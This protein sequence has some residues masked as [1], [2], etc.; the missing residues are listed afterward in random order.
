MFILQ[1]RRVLFIEKA[2]AV[3]GIL[4]TLTMTAGCGN[5]NQGNTTTAESQTQDAAGEENTRA[6][7]ENADNEESERADQKQT[8]GDNANTA[9]AEVTETGEESSKVLVAYYSAT[10]NTKAAAEAITEA[11]NGELFELQP[12]ET[13]T[14]EDLNYNDPE[15]RVCKEHD[16]PDLQDVKL[17]E[18]TPEDFSDVDVVFLGYPIWWGEA[19]WPVNEFVKEN[20]FTGKTVI[21]FCTSAS[22]GLGDSGKLLEEMAGTGDWQEGKRFSSNVSEEEIQDWVGSFDLAVK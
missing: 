7:S 19:A 13:Y 17:A 4:F 2:I 9:E 16:D 10:G 3:A 21:P 11:T 1:N 12:A 5:Q 6:Q 18:V 14:T 20:D 22:S 8:D 15:S